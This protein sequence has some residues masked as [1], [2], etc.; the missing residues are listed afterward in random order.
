M[1][2][3]TSGFVFYAVAVSFAFGIF[4]RSFVSLGFPEIIWFLLIAIVLAIV[5]GKKGGA[6]F[7]RHLTITSLLLF[8]FSLGIL[9]FEWASWYE[10]NPIFEN[11]VGEELIIEGIVTHE[12]SERANTTHLYVKANGELF[13]TIVDR[14]VAEFSYGDRVKVTATLKK[15]E[16]FETDL[17]RTFNYPG[18]L[19]A[20]GVSYTLPFAEIEIMERGQGNFLLAQIFS[21][22]SAF[23]EKVESLIPEPQ[24]GLSE[25]LL[26]GV[27]KALGEDLETVFRKTGIIH[28]VVL[29]GYNIMLVVIFIRY[30]L[31]GVLGRRFG[32][33][34]SLA[35]VALFAVMVG[36]SATVLRASIMAGLLILLGFT[37]RVYLVLR[38]LV[39]AGIIMLLI[40]PYLLAFDVGFQLSFLATLGLI[41]VAPF[42]DKKLTAVPN[43]WFKTREFLVA[44][45]ATQ[46]FV[47]PL[48]LYQIGEFSLV[49]VL[50]NVLVLPMVP[51]S[52]LLTFLSGMAAFFSTALAVPL[53]FADYL[54]LGYIIGIANW[55]AKL[56]LAS[57]IVPAFPFW[58]VPFAY[59]L[60]AYLVWYFVYRE[61]ETGD[62]SDW[63]IVEE[64]EFV[65]ET[66]TIDTPHFFK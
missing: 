28:I 27:K 32:S 51:V 25:G 64:K 39:L 36:L 12:P 63:T 56:P 10:K 60:I 62:L 3:E 37:G 21:F 16:S 65:P 59:G 26:L 11:K 41:L 50:V 54:S 18:Y 14:H 8:F 48:L 42:L 38:G 34:V 22:K 57:F 46:L 40:N 15:P 61:K 58:L 13:L 47:L 19:L 49:A 66:V 6:L 44:T 53:A 7:A 5:A 1:G 45:L 23:I 20:Q 31:G 24:A 4:I 55:F 30:I 52:M 33:L 2:S 43:K 17:G 9:R 35:G 29:S